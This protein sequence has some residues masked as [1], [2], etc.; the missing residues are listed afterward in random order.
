MTIANPNR[1]K[2]LTQNRRE[3]LKTSLFGAGMSFCFPKTFAVGGIEHGQ[4]SPLARKRVGRRQIHLDFH[5]SEYLPNIGEA[6]SKKQFQSAL[7][8]K[9]KLSNL[10][11]I[12]VQI[13]FI[14]HLV[15]EGLLD[16][17]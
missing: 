10:K 8:F 17:K 9:A 2:K 16:F 14:P 13:W 3:F 15:R 6:F 5:T 1:G 12:W 7:N 11:Q 4:S